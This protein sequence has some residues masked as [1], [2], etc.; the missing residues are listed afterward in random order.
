M[1]VIIPCAGRSSRF[2]GTRPKYL[3]TM[4]TGELMV[5]RAIKN[6]L[7]T[8][9]I[10]IILL[11]EHCDKYDAEFALK[12]LYRDQMNV[13]I[14]VL[15]KETSG[16]AETVYQIAKT[17]RGNDYLLIK[18]C[19]SFF[20][21]PIA[22]ENSVCVANLKKN[23][24]VNNVAAKSF[25]VFNE[26]DLLTNIV[27]KD[28]VS[29]Y[30]C[31]GGYE[32]SSVASFVMTY[33]Q[34][35]KSNPSEEIFI[36]HI[37]KHMLINNATFTKTEVENYIDVGTYKE[38]VDYNHSKPTIFCD[39]D[40]TI[41]YNQS[42]YFKNNY[43]NFPEPIQNAVKYML[44]KQ[45]EGCKI[46]FTTSRPEKYRNITIEALKECGF[47]NIS[48]LFNMPHSPRMVINDISKTNPYPTA[49]SMNVPRN[50][51]SYWEQLL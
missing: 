11:R 29:N 44:K 8:E 21:A 25:G 38:F 49:M 6:Y 3:L 2:P 23:L 5:E 40:G 19:D 47:T 14:H 50:D 16:P 22:Q 43:S 33:E 17:L 28:V 7:A 45:Q 15:E 20:D 4:H 42:A 34:V 35:I 18:D 30:I 26:H 10:H 46:I 48:V 24:H 32:F 41:F 36:S 51:N 37:I 39:I 1:A 13:H 27:E 9:D 12:M 31:V